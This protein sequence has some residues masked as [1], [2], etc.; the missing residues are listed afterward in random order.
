VVT[1]AP[2]GDVANRR[3]V[4]RYGWRDGLRH[5]LRNGL[6]YAH[7]GECICLTSLF[8]TLKYYPSDNALFVE[9]LLR[10]A[11][12]VPRGTGDVVVFEVHGVL[13]G[14]Q[15]FEHVHLAD[16]VA[17]PAAGTVEERVVSEELSLRAAHA[18]AHSP[19]HEAARPGSY[20]PAAR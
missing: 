2:R 19:V 15:R 3:V 12:T 14:E 1:V 10:Y 13:K 8:T 9:R 17:D 16:F 18:G 20:A 4:S 11:R 5:G 7:V 6:R